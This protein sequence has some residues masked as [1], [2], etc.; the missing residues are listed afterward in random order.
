MAPFR[1]EGIDVFRKGA[2]TLINTLFLA[3]LPSGCILLIHLWSAVAFGPLDLCFSHRHSLLFLMFDVDINV[4]ADA[5]CS[6]DP[7]LVVSQCFA[8]FRKPLS[9]WLVFL[10]ALL[11]PA[12]LIVVVVR[13]VVYLAVLSGAS[14][15]SHMLL[16][17]DSA[18]RI[19]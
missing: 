1:K 16:G 13:A 5:I 8:M 15:F 19:A 10:C 12:L 17:D 4:S 7:A 14:A 2:F 3:A 6:W 11:C 18:T 9:S